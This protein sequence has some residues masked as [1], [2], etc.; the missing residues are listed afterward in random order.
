MLR[1]LMGFCALMLPVT[2]LAQTAQEAGSEGTAPSARRFEVR[3]ATSAI[4]VDGVLDEQAWADALV[5]DLP[6]EWAPGDNTPPPV[7][8]DFL[9]AYDDE[10]LYAAWRAF[11]PE[12]SAIRAHLMDRDATDTLVQD[13][14]VVLM[15]DPF[16]DERRGFQFRVNPLG[17]QADAIFSQNEGVEDFSFDMIWAS[18]ARITSEG[19]I[20]EIAIPLDQIRFPR[21]GGMQTWGVDVG[22]SYPRNVRH[23]ISAAPIARGNNCLL[24]QISKVT[25]F[26]GLKPGRNLEVAPTVT[27]KRTDEATRLG[28]RLETGDEEVDPGVSARWGITPNVTLSAA[29][30]PDFSQV[31]ADVAQLDVNERFALF[32]PE[33]RPFF[34]EGIDI[35]ST[36]L[37][38]VFTRTVVDPDWGLKITGKEGRNAFGVFANDDQVNSFLI[39][40]NQ[41]TEFVLLDE[42][43]TSGVVRYRRDMGANSTLGALVTAREGDDYHNRV[44]GLDSFIRFNAANTLR[45][46]YLRSDTLYPRAVATAYGQSLDA[47]EGD[48]L[49]LDYEFSGPKWFGSLD[50]EDR[51]PGFR[52]DSGFVPRVDIREAEGFLQR[53][54]YGEQ[55]DWYTQWNVGLSVER[56]EDH[57]SVLTDEGI[58]LFTNVSGPR[59]SY[60][61]LSLEQN[62]QRVK[63]FFDGALQDVLY[64]D[65]NRIEGFFRVQPNRVAQLSLYADFGETVDF[66]N[67]QP[68]DIFQV[69]PTAEL[70]L[71][72]HLN[73]RIEHTLQRLD[74]E[75]GELFEANL[76]QLRLI[77]NFNVRSFVRGIFQY[78]DLQRDLSLFRD[79]ISPFFDPETEEFFTQLLFSYKLNPQTVLF[80]GYS[81]T[82]E[83]NHL[84][85]RTRTRQTFFFKVGYAWIL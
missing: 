40:S 80:L 51:D 41:G 8:T 15:I 16:N 73:A 28:G 66:T 5:F 31:E 83:G 67:N 74:V 6:Y 14:H 10:R 56:T 59:Q 3:R 27:A 85:E 24:C 42:S 68:A 21:T 1:Y 26:E 17:V 58:D 71:G 20:V 7:K 45:A 18:S 54:I 47:F 43:V 34:L 29:I 76:T 53:Q 49:V 12:P 65:M 72:Q 78:L 9:L 57:D 44:F 50:Y 84:V 63:S 32:F 33:K 79:E 39:P 19:Y 75:G 23:R 11:D 37:Q 35:F 2:G 82:E 36:P 46:Q 22:R 38:A 52:A 60:L 62:T 55:G 70:K 81:D 25:G 48:A 13:D 61:E 30:N 77:Y 4:R 69:V 64:E